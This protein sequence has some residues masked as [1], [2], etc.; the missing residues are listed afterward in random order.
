MDPDVSGLTIFGALEKAFQDHPSS[1][2]YDF[3]GSR[4]TCGDMYADIITFSDRLTYLG[5]KRGDRVAI[6]LPNIPQ[7]LIAFYA[8]NRIGA[9]SVMVHPLSSPN[10]LSFYVRD[11]D[12]R[13][14]I[15][16]DSLLGSFPVPG[17][18]ND[19]SFVMPVSPYAMLPPLKRLA[20]VGKRL[21]I[22]YSDSVVPWVGPT[23]PATEP[24]MSPEDPAV[25]L[26]T[27]GT[28]GTSKG[29]V[30]TNRSI[31]SSMSCMLGLIDISEVSRVLSIMPLFHGFGL[32]TCIHAP[33][34]IGVE[35]ILMPTFTIDSVCK[36]LVKKRIDAILGV[37]SLFKKM[38]ENP[39]LA[40]SDLSFI[41][42]M[43]CGG[44]LMSVS[45][46]REL[47]T[48]F[49]EHGAAG[50]QVGYGLTETVAAV[51]AMP[52][53]EYRED[54]VGLP[55]A[56]HEV[57]IV[58]L[59]TADEVPDGTEGEICIR[60]PSLMAGYLD[61][62]ETADKVFMEHP[63]GHVWLHTGDIGEKDA[64]GYL[65]FKGR[66]KRMIVTSGYN[67]YPAQ[68]EN[69][70]C[71]SPLVSECCVI[72]VPDQIRGEK[73]K[74]FVVLADGV[75]PTD[76]TRDELRAFMRSNIS[77]YSKPREYEFVDSLPKTKVGKIDYRALQD[78]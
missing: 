74:A 31:N 48:F 63:D 42:V 26:Y 49:R 15:I 25:V 68:V 37:P 13:A 34:C 60:G 50:V 66:F 72:G 17:D 67:V 75:P 36:A 46:L 70:L 10:E 7:A 5:V 6:C 3:L 73:V 9:V 27:G 69:T 45:D 59:G 56:D 1:P 21:R 52:K 11:S 18:D 23:A 54:S 77:A 39:I 32:C 4:R 22:S 2:A 19:L 62:S 14:A 41:R 71:R 51:A 47:N 78:S 65:L 44:D 64:D 43:F 40:S 16:L 8:V 30:H 57:R 58:G 33:L 76:E 24:D 29:A 38:V 12:C 20:T 53:G 35:C 55:L 28:T 61:G